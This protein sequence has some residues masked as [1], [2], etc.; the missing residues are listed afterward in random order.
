MRAYAPRR[1]SVSIKRKREGGRERSVI[2]LHGVYRFSG[3]IQV[4]TTGARSAV[5][6]GVQLA[7]SESG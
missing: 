7:Q 3:I 5:I 1:F 4:V 2:I 6:T